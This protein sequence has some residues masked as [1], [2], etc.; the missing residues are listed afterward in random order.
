M[1]KRDRSLKRGTEVEVFRRRTL[2][3]VEVFHHRLTEAMAWA[4]V[5][6]RDA[7]N[8]S[9]RFDYSAEGRRASCVLIFADEVDAVLFGLINPHMVAA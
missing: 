6:S 4:E 9:A 2:T 3:E 1:A 5:N 8:A 7:W